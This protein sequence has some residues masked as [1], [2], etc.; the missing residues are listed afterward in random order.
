MQGRFWL[1]TGAESAPSRAFVLEV[2]MQKCG[3]VGVSVLFC[4][5]FLLAS[6]DIEGMDAELGVLANPENE[7]LEYL[8]VT[9]HSEW[10]TSGEV[11]VDPTRYPVPRRDG[12]IPPSFI[13]RPEFAAMLGQGT[14][15]RE[16]YFF[17]GWQP[18]QGNVS[19]HPDPDDASFPPRQ[20][21]QVLT[22]V[23]FD[24][25]WQEN[26]SPQ[27]TSPID[28]LSL[29]C[30][31][32]AMTIIDTNTNMRHGSFTKNILATWL[33]GSL[34]AEDRPD[35]NNRLMM[36]GR[37]RWKTGEKQGGPVYCEMEVTSM[38]WRMV[39]NV[40]VPVLFGIGAGRPVHTEVEVLLNTDDIMEVYLILVLRVITADS[41]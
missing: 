8:T 4:I 23:D 5:V 16:G 36:T 30:D 2:D 39:N 11:P 35:G 25:V 7:G 9:Y 24:A 38:N 28:F 37:T 13:V 27:N 19:I 26:S 3:F 10:H 15:E 14:L 17:S 20:I 40:Q 12:L 1:V 31:D 18:R 22:N 41:N 29:S 34:P 6:C 32:K 33:N 21:F